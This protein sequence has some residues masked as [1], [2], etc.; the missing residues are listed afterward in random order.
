MRSP[1]RRTDRQRPTEATDRRTG[2]ISSLVIA[3]RE[4][5]EVGKRA[6][7]GAN[8]REVRGVE[9]ARAKAACLSSSSSSL[10]FGVDEGEKQ[11]ARAIFPPA[12][13][14]SGRP[15]EK[16]RKEGR[17]RVED[18]EEEESEMK[19]CVFSFGVEDHGGR[20]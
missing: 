9:G 6:A 18:E 5:N 2:R 12:A 3:A 11:W 13:R 1:S 8:K 15:G 19:F 17:K 14:A 7:S 4:K 10:P 20:R 16:G